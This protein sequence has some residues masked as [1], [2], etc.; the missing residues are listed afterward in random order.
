MFII[1]SFIEIKQPK[2]A[3]LCRL[4]TRINPINFVKIMHGTRPLGA[5]ILVKFHFFSFGGRKPPPLSRSRWYLAGRSATVRSSLPNFTLIG[6]ACRPCGAKNPKT[7]TW[8]KTIPAELPAADP[9]GNNNNNNNKDI[10]NALNSPKPQIC[11]RLK[12][13]RTSRS[14]T[15]I[16]LYSILLCER[17]MKYGTLSA[18]RS[19]IVHL[20]WVSPHTH[21]FQSRLQR[22]RRVDCYLSVFE[23]TLNICTPYRYWLLLIIET[24]DR[25]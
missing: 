12:V 1:L 3:V 22:V 11:A 23:R 7:T 25:I 2:L 6:A 17:G 9:A 20:Y 14:L 15:N 19:P 18:L 16:L 5:I 10:C 21:L 13:I 24:C 4:S 8:V